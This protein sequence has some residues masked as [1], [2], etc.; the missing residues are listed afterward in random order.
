MIKVKHDKFL[1]GIEFSHSRSCEKCHS[2]SQ[3]VRPGSI[4]VLVTSNSGFNKMED[5]THFNCSQ[6]DKY[7][8][9]DNS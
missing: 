8:W 4:R 3:Y 7:P 2:N 5:Y 6:P 9:L 1:Q